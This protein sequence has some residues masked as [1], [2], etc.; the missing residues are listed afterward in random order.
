MNALKSIFLLIDYRVCTFF[1]LN[2]GSFYLIFS[3]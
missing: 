3:D 1:L 2:N